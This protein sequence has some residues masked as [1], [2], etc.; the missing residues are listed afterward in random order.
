MVKNILTKHILVSIFGNALEFYE[1][2]VFMFLTPII[3]KEFFPNFSSFFSMLLTLSIFATGFFMRPIGA[4]LFG[5]IGDKYGR[6]EALSFSILF[7]AVPTFLIGVCPTYAQIGTLAPFLILILRLLQGICTGGEYNGSAIYAVENGDSQRSGCIGGFITSSCILGSVTGSLVSL[8][9]SFPGMPSWSWRIAFI[10]GALGGLAGYFFRCKTI[11]SR[12]ITTELSQKASGS[13]FKEGLT[14][15]LRN[16]LCILGIS[17]FS[18]CMT[19]TCFSYINLYLITFKNWDKHIALTITSLGMI[20]YMILAPVSGHYSD[21]Y[22]GKKIMITGALL[23]ILLIYPCFYA[24]SSLEDFFT[25]LCV[26]ILLALSAAVFQGPMNGF[27]GRLF[28]VHYRYRGVAVSYSIG[29]ALF[30]GTASSVLMTLSQY[31]NEIV[32][33]FSYISL[34]AVLGIISTYGARQSYLIRSSI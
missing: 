11:E 21:K 4:L 10:L 31:T 2:T 18:G 25:I 12:I 28:P 6:K 34:I 9:L 3:S 15:N 23:T 30:G 5:Y 8:I 26:Q 32:A 7:M 20:V 17:G 22:G 14:M 24:L 1:F 33:P 27:M 19:Y 29:M 16:V 13:S